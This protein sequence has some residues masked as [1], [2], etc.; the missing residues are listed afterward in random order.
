MLDNEQKQQD[1]NSKVQVTLAVIALIGTISGAIIANWDKISPKDSVTP[2]S[3]LGIPSPASVNGKYSSLTG[4]IECPR[5]YTTY[6][7]FADY[8]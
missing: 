2:N 7:E 6:G 3:L 8:G 4:I 5:D 1:S